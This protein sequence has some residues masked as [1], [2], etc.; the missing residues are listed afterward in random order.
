MSTKEIQ[1]PPAFPCEW[2]YIGTNREAANG[3]P[4]R[5]YAAIHMA[6]KG[7]VDGHGEAVAE[8]LIGRP[9]PNL[10]IDPIGYLEW[11]AEYRCKLRYIEADAMLKA[12]IK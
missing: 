5:D 11:R 8:K 2:D 9:C 3:M 12:R 10:S 6:V 7:D 4:L 1:N